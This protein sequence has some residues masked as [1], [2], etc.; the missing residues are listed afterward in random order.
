MGVGQKPPVWWHTGPTCTVILSTNS[1]HH[2]TH[3]DAAPGHSI[4]ILLIPDAARADTEQPAYPPVEYDKHNT[5]NRG[6]SKR[7]E[8]SSG[9]RWHSATGTC[10]SQKIKM[11]V[12]YSYGIGRL[13][14]LP[15]FPTVCNF[16][17]QT[18]LRACTCR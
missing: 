1:C 13:E 3:S 2:R 10:A 18:L 7:M 6:W 12:K 15:S 9:L 17:I 8:N 16:L 4:T 11:K 14:K 5:H